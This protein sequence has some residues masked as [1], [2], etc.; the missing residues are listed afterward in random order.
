MLHPRKLRPE[1]F[2]TE[3]LAHV[4]PHGRL[5]LLGLWSMAGKDRTI[6][7]GTARIRADVFPYEP[8][9]DM[10]E[11]L[12]ELEDTLEPFITRET[13]PAD[14]DFPEMNFIIVHQ[15]VFEEAMLP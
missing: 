13:I 5:L 1:F 10:E 7:H 9:I 2:R 14:D 4:S 11:L 12:S 6:E 15:L 8:D 3:L